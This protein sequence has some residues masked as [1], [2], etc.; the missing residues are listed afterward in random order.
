ME[1]D[2]LPAAAMSTP[3][4]RTRFWLAKRTAMV[5]ATAFLAINLWTGAPLIALW[6][7]SQVVGQTVLSME[8]VGVVVVVLAVLVFSMSMALAWLSR[9][10]D[11][12]SGREPGEQRLP[13]LRG[14]SGEEGIEQ[15]GYGAGITPLERVVMVSVYLA[16]ICFLLWFFLLAGA[17]TPS[18]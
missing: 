8:A 4:P 13:W 17:P 16:V 14:M 1:V 12:L 2:G 9:E 6:V 15:P 18:L 5:A 7:G 11:R 10:Y 3:V